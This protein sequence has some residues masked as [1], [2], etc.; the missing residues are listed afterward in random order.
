MI[1]KTLPYLMV[2]AGL[3]GLFFSPEDLGPPPQKP[4]ALQSLVISL[5]LLPLWGKIL[6]IAIRVL[7]ISGNSNDTDHH[8]N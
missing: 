1:L 6:S 4:N 5:M 8:K 2:L 7:W 3:L